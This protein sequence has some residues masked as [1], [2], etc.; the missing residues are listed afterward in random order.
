[1]KKVLCFFF[2]LSL[3]IC[4]CSQNNNIFFTENEAGNFVSPHGVAYTFFAAEYELVYLGELEFYGRVKGEPKT[5]RHLNL[6]MQTGFFR[7]KND[8]THNFLIRRLP[9][10]EWCSIYR[11]T[12]FEPFD[13]SGENCIR[14]ETL[15][16]HTNVPLEPGCE[17][18]TCN[19]G[20]VDPAVIQKFFA[21]IHTQKNPREAGL[22]DLVQQP[23]AT[24]Q[25]C[26]TSHYVYGFFKQEPHLALKLPITSYNDLA[27][28]IAIGAN[29]Y[30][31]TQEWYDTLTNN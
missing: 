12:S 21:E 22:Y 31:L 27:Y 6:S 29:E 3:L 8:E 4:G 15:S 10:N 16:H 25:N 26:Y 13:F 5:T 2:T 7:F 20:I 24:L 1:M 19:E 18:L 9:D 23:D 28:S 14:L 17:H 11:K 30:V